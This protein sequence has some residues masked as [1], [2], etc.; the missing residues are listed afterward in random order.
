M[1]GELGAIHVDTRARKRQVITFAYW[2]IRE[3]LEEQRVAAMAELTSAQRSGLTVAPSA[4]KLTALEDI[5]FSF[6]QQLIKE[7]SHG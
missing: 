6:E 4:A 3:I 2:A 1:I 7:P 5:S